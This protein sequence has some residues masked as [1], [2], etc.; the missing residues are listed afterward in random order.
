M[1]TDDNPYA[2]PQT[3]NRK[4]LVPTKP[5]YSRPHSDFILNCFFIGP[6]YL[7]GSQLTWLINRDSKLAQL[8]G[9][10]LLFGMIYAWWMTLLWGVVVITA[11]L[12]E[13]L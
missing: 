5:W 3:D 2:A 1:T 12:I 9:L 13:L 8:L 4:A 7:V 6:A 11:M 10:L